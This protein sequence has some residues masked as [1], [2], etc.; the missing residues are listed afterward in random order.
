MIFKIGDSV[1]GIVEEEIQNMLKFFDMVTIHKTN[2]LI[3]TSSKYGNFSIW[4]NEVSYNKSSFSY[5]HINF[6]YD[7]VLCEY[8]IT[9]A[10][11]ESDSLIIIKFM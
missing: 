5:T 2:T 11:D 3:L 7:K 10:N 1:N 8:E 4:D 6:R 9:I